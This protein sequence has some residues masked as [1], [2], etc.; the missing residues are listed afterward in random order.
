MTSDLGSEG[1][2][3]LAVRKLERSV[4][5][6]EQRLSLRMAE[7][8]A[9]VGGLFD[10]DRARLAAELDAARGREHDLR[11]AGAQASAALA[12]AIAQMR[13]QITLTED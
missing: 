9:Q 5:L 11:E 4:T 2:L 3:D 7:A 10:Q 12:R 1:R 8:G 6:L 13:A